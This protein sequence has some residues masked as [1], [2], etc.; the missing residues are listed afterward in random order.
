M[1]QVEEVYFVYETKKIES[2]K[3]FDGLQH[4]SILATKAVF[5][6]AT[7]EFTTVKAL[8]LHYLNI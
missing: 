2:N 5:H 3:M 4:E 8:R 1:L 6:L 7:D